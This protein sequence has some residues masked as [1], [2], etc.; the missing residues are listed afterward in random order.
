MATYTR[1]RGQKNRARARARARARL[2][3]STPLVHFLETPLLTDDA[4]IN[5]ALL[6]TLSPSIAS[7][8]PRLQ[9]L[10]LSSNNLGVPGASATSELLTNNNQYLLKFGYSGRVLAFF[11]KFEL[12]L[13]NT[14]INAE[15]VASLNIS[16]K[17]ICCK[18]NLEDNPL[19]YDGL[20]AIFRSETCPIT[21]LYLGNTGLTIPVNSESQYHNTQLPSTI[22]VFNLGQAIE[23]NTLI[24]LN[25]SD[26]NF[27]GDK[28]LIL[29]EC[30][31]V[32]KSLGTLYCWRCSLTA[33]EVLNISDHLESCG[34]SHE[35]LRVWDLTSNSIDVEGVNALIE[36][37]P[38][39][40]PYLEKVN[41]DKIPVS[42]ENNERLQKILKVIIHPLYSSFTVYKFV[43][44]VTAV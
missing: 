29:A 2:Y 32:C 37:L 39:L 28:A 9:K 21:E 8:C 1:G 13:S 43:V 41:F 17:P 20:L 25:L 11:Q 18:L 3:L 5:G 42:G 16:S 31:R 38:Q 10:G 12:D 23:N 14:N 30:V 19:G 40:F 44:S 27:S 34:C 35:N 6:A 36:S 4:D 26:N 7:H 24:E 22:S 15:A 33:N